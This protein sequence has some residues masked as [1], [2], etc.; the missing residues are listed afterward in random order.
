MLNQLVQTYFLQ[1]CP[2]QVQ[3][4]IAFLITEVSAYYGL[5]NIKMD[6]ELKLNI[7]DMIIDLFH[8][9]KTQL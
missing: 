8:S 4:R 5:S 2:L 7:Q 6:A 3:S 1:K 9:S